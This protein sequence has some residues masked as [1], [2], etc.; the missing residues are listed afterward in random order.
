MAIL[1]HPSWVLVLQV[2]QQ[3]INWSRFVAATFGHVQKIWR[4]L[5]W[6]ASPFVGPTLPCMKTGK[7]KPLI[8]V[9]PDFI[10]FRV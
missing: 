7:M 6:A 3:C 4:C 8:L 10:M 2:I 1:N 5:F 9:Y